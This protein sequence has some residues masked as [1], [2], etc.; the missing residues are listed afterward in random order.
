MSKYEFTKVHRQ[1][2]S[3]S[4]KGVRNAAG[5]HQMTPRGRA[6]LRLA[7]L[8]RWLAFY[9]DKV[10]KEKDERKRNKLLAKVAATEENIEKQERRMRQ[11]GW[12]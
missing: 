7:Q 8:K 6:N 5:P 3:D 9:Q 1:R 10:A 11:H 12:I 2:L 4:L